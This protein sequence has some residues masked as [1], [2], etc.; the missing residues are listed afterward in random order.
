MN[1]PLSVVVRELAP[2]VLGVLVRR[3]ADFAACEDAVQDALLAATTQWPVDGWPDNPRNWLIAVA[4]RRLHDARRAASARRDRESRIVAREPQLAPAPDEQP[5]DIDDTLTV[6][7]L[8]CHPALSPSSQL[9]LTLRAVG[10][11][12]TAEIAHS[13]LVPETTMAQRISRAKSRIRTS[14]MPFRL[15]SEADR[16]ARL[17]VVLHVLYLI[18]TEGHTGSG[19]DTLHRVELTGEAIRLV[20]ILHRLLPR[21]G[22]V[23]GLLALMLLVE[24]RRVTRADETGAL[25]PLA[26]QDRSR[27]DHAAIAEGIDLIT[28][29]LGTAPVGP[30]QIQA[31]I[32]ALHAEAQAATDTDWGQI[33]ML[34]RI[35][36]TLFPNPMARLNLAVAAAMVDGPSEALRLVDD[37]AKTASLGHRIDAVRGHLLEMSND[38]AGARIHYL[39]AARMTRSYPERLYLQRKA[40]DAGRENR[41]SHHQQRERKKEVR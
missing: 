1:P 39:A 2:L 32:A 14:N 21:H 38:P 18:F 36:D 3:H 16:P 8:C 27:W 17:K 9:A 30:Y 7:F 6:L 4:E 11:L 26:E 22:E 29:T 15:P 5:R 20:R 33:L 34:Y 23:T 13:F 40:A 25:A 10:G 24:A 37:L 35:L 12:T 41:R 19:G 31:A 28:G